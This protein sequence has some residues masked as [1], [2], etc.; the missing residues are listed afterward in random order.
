MK[1]NAIVLW[2]RL[3]FTPVYFVIFFLPNFYGY[4]ISEHKKYSLQLLISLLVAGGMGEEGLTIRNQ[5]YCIIL[6]NKENEK[7]KNIVQSVGG[8]ER[9]IF[10]L[11]VASTLERKTFSMGNGLFDSIFESGK[12]TVNV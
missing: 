9:I 3:A 1:G 2:E 4:H 11:F 7:R 6:W 10:C 5:G 12:I 8:R